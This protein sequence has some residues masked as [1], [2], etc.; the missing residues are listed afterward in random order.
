MAMVARCDVFGGKPKRFDATKTLA[1]PGVHRVLEIPS[2]I[3]VLADSTWAAL[4][5]REALQV[6]WDLGAHA[7]LDTETLR[8][9]FARLGTRP[10][11]TAR[12]EGDAGK[13]LAG[14]AHHLEAVYE[15]PFLAHAPLEPMNCI[16]HVR[17]D[18]ADIWAPTQAPQWAQQVVAGTLGL[19]LEQVKIHTTLSGGAFGRRAM[20]DFV[21]EAVHVSRAAGGP[22]QVVWTR[23]DDMHHDFYRPMSLHRLSAGLDSERRLTAWTHRLV[24][25]SIMAQAFPGEKQDEYDAVDG[26]ANL[27]YAV[28]NLLI[29]YVLADTPVPVGWWRSVYNTQNA[30]VNECFLDEIAAASAQDPYALRQQLLPAGSRLRRTLEHEAIQAAWRRPPTAGSSRG[31]AT[32][33]CFGTAVAQ[34]AEVSVNGSGRVHVHQVVCALDCGPVV[35]PDT[36]EAQVEGAIAYGLSAALYGEITLAGGRVQQSSFDDYNVLRFDEMPDVDVHIVPSTDA[37]GGIG[38]PGLPPLAPAVCNAVFAA[39]GRR[40]RRLPLRQDELRRG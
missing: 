28:P 14:A 18:G 25:P 10:G 5:G 1:V 4:R 39:T 24:A 30:F 11:V 38:E 23:E 12:Q 34:V 33:E 17:P 27:A 21:V 32:H 19:P 2:G 35:N 36:V 6:E 16:A 40:V 7:K 20:Y 8:Q 13:A 26:A 29:D 22:V 3:A 15:F 9:T 37:I 31:L